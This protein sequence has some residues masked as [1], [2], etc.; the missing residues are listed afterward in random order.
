MGEDALHAASRRFYEAA[1]AVL[2][3]DSGPMLE[4]WSASDDVSYAAPSGE[5]VSGATALQAYWDRAAQANMAV[6]GM[7]T[8]VGED[9]VTRIAGPIGYT[10]TI[11]RI[12]IHQDEAAG[13]LRARATNVYRLEDGAWRLLHRHA[14]PP[15]E[16][17]A[18]APNAQDAGK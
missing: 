4:L 9:V 7:M 10:V 2:R 16:E 13:H 3:G 12:T 8:A 15:V 1:N 11:E 14:E 6:P 5:I 18:T 17:A